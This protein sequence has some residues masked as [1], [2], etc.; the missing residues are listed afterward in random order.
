MAETF[1]GAGLPHW[2]GRIRGTGNWS[3]HGLER[4]LCFGRLNLRGSGDAED[5]DRPGPFSVEARFT[6]VVVR[7]EDEALDDYLREEQ[8]W[9]SYIEVSP[10]DP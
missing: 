5:E 9:F 7:R 10:G 8:P 4:G 6:R 2:R 1:R 3:G